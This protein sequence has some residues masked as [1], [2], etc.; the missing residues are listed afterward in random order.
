GCGCRCRCGTAWRRGRRGTRTAWKH[1]VHTHGW[2]QHGFQAR[3]RR[4]VSQILLDAAGC[5]QAVVAG[6][7][8][9]HRERIRAFGQEYLELGG[10][11][12]RWGVEVGGLPPDD[13]LP[14]GRSSQRLAKDTAVWAGA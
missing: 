2:C 5:R 8:V 9:D 6:R 13:E 1:V 11:G 7:P 14:V 4:E 3:E 12:G 10:C